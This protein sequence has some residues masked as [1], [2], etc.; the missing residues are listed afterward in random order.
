M[1]SD[2]SAMGA[3]CTTAPLATKEAAF[4]AAVFDYGQAVSRSLGPIE[5][6]HGQGEDRTAAQMNDAYAAL[7]IASYEKQGSMSKIDRKSLYP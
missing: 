1:V 2:A 3:G 4:E 6:A 7:R 5:L